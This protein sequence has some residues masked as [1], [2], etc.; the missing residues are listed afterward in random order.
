MRWCFYNV[1][2]ETEKTRHFRHTCHYI[3][4]ILFLFS[5]FIPCPF[6]LRAEYSDNANPI[7]RQLDRITK[8]SSHTKLLR[9]TGLVILIMR[10]SVRATQVIEIIVPSLLKILSCVDSVIKFKM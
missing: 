4:C 1:V 10:A 8:V 3:S 2:R 6:S 5:R 9:V 7:Q